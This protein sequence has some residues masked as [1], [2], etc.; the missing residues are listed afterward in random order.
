MVKTQAQQK[1]YVGHQ[2][3]GDHYFPNNI[4]VFAVVFECS[5]Y[6]QVTG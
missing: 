2:N 3:P 4:V 1:L 5:P 6:L